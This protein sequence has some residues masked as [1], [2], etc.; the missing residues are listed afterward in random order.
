VTVAFVDRR[1]TGEA[2]AAAV[3]AEGVELIVVKHREAKNGFVL[4]P[5]RWVVGRTVGGWDGP[6]GRR[7][8]TSGCPRRSRRGTGS[9]SSR[10][11]WDGWDFKVRN[12]L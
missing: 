7:G 4:L 1:Y 5:R 3:A 2:T 11:C 12:R 8:T 9:R 10:S 6:A